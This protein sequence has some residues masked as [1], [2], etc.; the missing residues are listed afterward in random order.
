MSKKIDEQIEN[1]VLGN[2]TQQDNLTFRKKMNKNSLLRKNVM[3]LI[4]IAFAALSFIP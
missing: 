2:M 3:T 1:Y 4:M